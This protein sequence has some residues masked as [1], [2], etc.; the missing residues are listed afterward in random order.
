[1]LNDFLI[2]DIHNVIFV[3]KEDYPEMKTAFHEDLKTYELIFH[4]SGKSTVYFNEKVLP[5]DENTVRYLPKGKVDRYIVDRS[6]PGE[7][8]DIFFQADKPPADEAFVFSVGENKQIGQLFNRMFSVWVRK[9]NG[10]RY[11]CLS[12]LYMILAQLQRQNY[13]PEK[14]YQAIYPALK[15][16]EANFLRGPIPS[17][18]LA[19][20]CGISYSYIK[21]LFV[22]RF[23]VPPKKYI[24][25]MKINYAG[26]LLRSGMYSVSQIA[27]LCGFSD[28]YYFS[29]QFKEYIGLS[30]TAY[31]QKH[32]PGNL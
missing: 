14:Q 15:Y 12:I 25:Q 6:A 24:L 26:D 4:I 13:I 5:V 1:M 21:K 2:T 29:R 32:R 7:C 19:S 17:E 27:E 23:G 3:S 11:E 22:K 18:K 30:P 16:I 10:Y 20:L 8:I 28:I 31:I 9:E